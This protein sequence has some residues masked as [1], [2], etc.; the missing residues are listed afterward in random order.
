M[1]AGVDLNIT[2]EP[3]YMGPLVESVEEGRVPMALVDRAVRRV[4]E[5]K[6]RLGLF[7]HPYVDVDRAVQVVHSRGNQELALRAGREGIVLLKNEKN[8]LPLKK[9]LKSIAVIGPNADDARNQ[10]GD[11][12]PKT[13]S[14][15]RHDGARGN[16]GRSLAADQSHCGARLRSDRRGQE[17]ICRGGGGRKEPDV[18]IV[19]VGESEG[20]RTDRD[21]TDG[22]GHDVASLDLS[23]RAGGSDP[24][25]LGNG[26]TDGRRADQRPAAFH[27]LDLRTR[28]RARRGVGARRT[29]R[30]GR[31]RRALRQLQSQRAA[32]HFGSAPF[33]PIAGLLQLQ[34]LEGVLDAV[35]G[36]RRYARDAALSFRLRAELHRFEYS[37]LR[38]DPAE[39]RTGGEAHVSLDVNNTGDARGRGN[40]P[41]LHSRA[42]RAGFNARETASRIRASGAEPG[43]DENRDFQAY[44]RRSSVARH[45]HALARGA[46]RFRNH[47]GQVVGEDMPLKGTL[48]VTP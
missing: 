36:L 14:P 18:A 47:G 41:A 20:Q 35:G 28:A 13:R 29:R 30:R 16:Q 3:A 33:R 26:H 1:S 17:R 46:G 38:I 24:G 43:A 15:A 34:T 45:R 48:K 11:Y 42:I 25:G 22:E 5:L 44:S 27:A 23:R 37:N 10:L 6:F 12:S 8:L 9:D 39:I 19:V 4:L 40:R 21:P 31:G 2:Y 7:E 32:G